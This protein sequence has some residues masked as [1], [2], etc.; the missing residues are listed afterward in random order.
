M[1]FPNKLYKYRAFNDR[2]LDQAVGD[3]LFYADPTT[4]NDPLDTKPNLEADL[5]EFA[6]AEILNQLLEQRI[7]AEMDAAAKM[8][9]YKGPKTIN[10]ISQQSKRRAQGM[11][12]QVREGIANI[13][14]EFDATPAEIFSG[15]IERELL[16]RYDKGIISMAE[17]YN[18]PLMWSHYGDQHRGICF[19]YSIPEDARRHLYKVTY[20]GDRTVKASSVQAML[21]GSEDARQ[22]V[23]AAVLSR[24][25]PDWEYEKEW[26]LVGTRGV[27]NSPLELEEIIFGIRCSQTVKFSL[28]RSLN[29]RRRQVSFYE[30]REQ[31]GAFDLRR[32]ELDQT[33]LLAYFPRRSLDVYDHFSA[34]VSAIE[35]VQD[36]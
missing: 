18:C 26:R 22:L 25:A 14:D 23:D 2:S 10:H 31:R 24:K 17:R 28:L 19:G 9:K 8:I 27:Q 29:E 4:F 20:D 15:F 12:D 5:D 32:T 6:L 7:Q 33:D 21:R 34:L 36:N 1:T 30:M 16:R 13:D 3:Q 35:A 11:V